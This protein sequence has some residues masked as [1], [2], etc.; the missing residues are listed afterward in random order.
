SNTC[1]TETDWI[2][3][4]VTDGIRYNIRQDGSDITAQAQGNAAVYFVVLTGSNDFSGQVRG[5]SFE[6]TDVGP[7]VKPAGSCNYTINAVVS[8]AIDGDTIT[9]KVTYHPVISADPSCDPDCAPYVCEA[10]QTF[11]GTRAPM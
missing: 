10:E 4:A 3:D 2:D 9:G 5:N 11:V 6:L 8:G 7:N 1:V